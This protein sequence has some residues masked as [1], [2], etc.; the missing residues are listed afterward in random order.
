MSDTV[1]AKVLGSHTVHHTPVEGGPVEVKTAAD[2][3]FKMRKSEFDELGPEG[4]RAVRAANEKD[5]AGPLDH[6][7][8]GRNGGAAPPA[9]IQ[10]QTITLEEMANWQP[11]HRGGGVFDVKNGETLVRGDFESK[12]AAQEWI[13]AQRQAATG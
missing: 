3:P 11:K 12:D 6:D 5:K 1:L 4:L 9:S 7:N 2:R 10:H 8:D 13:V